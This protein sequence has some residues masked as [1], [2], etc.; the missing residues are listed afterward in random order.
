MSTAHYKPKAILFDWDNTLA[1]S[2]YTVVYCMNK[3]LNRYNKDCWEIVKKQRNNDKSL[4]ENFGIFFQEESKKAYQDYVA[5]YLKYY[6]KMTKRPLNADNLI[7]FLKTNAINLF[8]VSN[9]EKVLLNAEISFLY[10]IKQFDKILGA[11]DFEKNKPAPDSVYQCINNKFPINSASVWLVGD[12][13]Q[14]LEC[15]YSSG[16]QPV[17]IGNGN[18]AS[19]DYFEDRLSSEKPFLRFSSIDSFFSY[20]KEAF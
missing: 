4:K 9:K 6:K 7:S 3:V 11:G 2:R 10:D 19:R 1:E 5:E 18:L 14:D 15:A 12:S 13:K 20:V 16:C 8:V 17:L